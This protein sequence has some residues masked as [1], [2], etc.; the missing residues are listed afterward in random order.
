MS[1][2]AKID[3]NN[4]VVSVI[5]AE[6]DYIDTLPDANSWLQTS[7][8]TRRN[9]HYKPNSNEPSG[10]PAFRGNFAGLGFTY[11]PEND[12]FIPVKPFEQWVLNTEIWDYE[13]PNP[14]PVP[15]VVFDDEGFI[16]GQ[17]RWSDADY[18]AGNSGWVLVPNEV[19]LP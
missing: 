1:H 15:D 18:V 16:L 7:Y 2:F 3:E 6:Q 13:P 9:V 10:K 19:E 14:A 5:V 11:D 17:Y 8:N 12:V 4:V